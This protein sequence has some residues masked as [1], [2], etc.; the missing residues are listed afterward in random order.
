MTRHVVHNGITWTLREGC[1]WLVTCG[2][3]DRVCAG[4]QDPDMTVVR[5]NIIRRSALLRTGTAECS[6]VFVKYYKRGGMRDA[7][8]YL[9][10][11]SK[12]VRE[13]KSLRLCERLGIPCP[14]PLAYGERRDR[15]ILK[16]SY[17]ITQSLA[18][19]EPLNEYVPQ[20][21]AHGAE[22]WLGEALA[23]LVAT[24][25]RE[26]IYYRDLHGGNILVRT[27]GSA[28]GAL[29]CV[30]LHR[31]Y[32]LP[33]LPDQLA[34]DDIAHLCNSLPAS[35][36]ERLRFLRTYCLVRFGHRAA[37]NKLR[38]LI[39]R[40]Q[41]L[42]E[43]R[44]IRSRSKRCMVSSTQFEVRH[45]VRETYYGRRDFGYGSACCAIAAHRAQQ[46][47]VLKQ[48]SASCISVH[49]DLDREPVC[50]KGY[51]MR[52]VWSALAQVVGL[53]RARKSWRAAHG[54]VVRGVDTP[55]PLAL[56]ERR[57][58]IL[59]QQSYFITRWLPDALELNTYVQAAGFGEK[60]REFVAALAQTIRRLHG[61]GIYHG[62]MKSNNILVVQN[63][64]TAWRFYFVDLDRVHF[65]RNLSFRQRA[66]NLAQINASVAASI[67]VRDRLCFFH[68]YAHGTELWH[69]RKRYYRAILAIS[70][71]KNTAPY[72]VFFSSGS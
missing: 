13:W 15:G 6:E 1:T 50:V 69:E 7:L 46:G 64:V 60:K 2:L 22:R 56:V 53:S 59:S 5:D 31:A 42:L 55:L 63:G 41:R 12:V 26:R 54:L 36:S 58:G 35:R 33:W 27:G 14:R 70:R 40:R 20:R 52:G 21:A 29:V 37:E 44:R 61:Q 8:K 11:P 18:P 57:T 71:K 25:H 72:G 66:N 51:V 28:A 24:L 9:F 48:A 49:P 68:V 16:D 43:E 62:D 39:L 30:D 4:M 23:R 3:L 45:T 67:T 10:L 38:T 34:A 47:R 17:L 32:R 19:A 65:Y